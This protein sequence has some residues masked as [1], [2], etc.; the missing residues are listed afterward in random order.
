VKQILRSEPTIRSK[1]VDWS[2][3]DLPKSLSQDELDDALRPVWNGMRRLPYGN[4]EIADACGSVV[5]LLMVGLRREVSTEGQIKRFSDCF[6]E[7]MRVEF[8]NFDGSSSRGLVALESLRRALR[9]DITEL[10]APEFKK[11]ADDVRELFKIIY[12]PRL[13]FEFEEFKKIFAREVIPTQTVEKRDLILFNPAR[14]MAFG[15][16]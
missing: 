14:L 10:L 1:T 6:A 15:L 5:A 9:T 12:Y 13:M 3:K 11:Y 16:P 2:F 4:D 7:C 8:S